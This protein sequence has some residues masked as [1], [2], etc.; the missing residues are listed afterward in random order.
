MSKKLFA[1]T[2]LIVFLLLFSM[3]GL[4]ANTTSVPIQLNNGQVS[5]LS[6]QINMFSKSHEL[7][8]NQYLASVNGT[9]SRVSVASDGTEGNSSSHGPSISTDGRFIAYKSHASNLVSGDTNGWGDIFMY[10]QQ[11]GETIRVSV[12]SDGTQANGNCINA[13]ISADGQHVAFD[14][15]AR[16]LVIGDNNGYQDIFV[17]D[18]VTGQT[19]LVSVGSNS[20]QTNQSSETPS[21]SADGSNVAFMSYATNISDPP[22]YWSQVFAHDRQTGLTER[23][24]VA[25]DGTV[26]NIYS[27]DPS[28]SAD[29]RYV[30][31]YSPGNNLVNGDTNGVGDVFLHDQQTGETIR[32]SVA[33]NGTQGNGSSGGG[34]ISSDG[35]YVAFQSSANNLVSED[36]NGRIDI[37]VHDLQTGLTERVSLASDG[38]EGN[39][40]SGAPSISGDGRYVTFVSYASN[41]VTGDTNGLIDVFVHDRQTGLT[42]RVSV[43]SDGTE[44]N[45][46][47]FT[48]SISGDGRYVTFSSLASNLVIGDNNGTYDIFV[49][50]RGWDTTTTITSDTPDPS[51]VG[52]PITVNFMVDGPPGTNMPTGSVTVTVEG[53]VEFCNANLV[54]GSGSCMITITNPGIYTLIATYGGDDNFNG[55]SDVEENT[56]LGVVAKDDS[57]SLVEGTILDQDAPGGVLSNDTGVGL[58]VDGYDGTS[59]FD[60][61]VT[62]NPDGSFVYTPAAGFAG[63]DTFSYTVV[64]GY[65]DFDTA[66]VE[67]I[68]N[69]KNQRSIEIESVEGTVIGQNLIGTVLISDQSENG[70]RDDLLVQIT[71]FETFVWWKKGKVWFRYS[72]ECAN[73]PFVFGDEIVVQ[74]ECELT[75][76]A[77]EGEVF[78]LDVMV[79]IFGREKGIYV[80]QFF[81]EKGGRK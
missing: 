75:Q 42:E 48:P 79:S 27:V 23:V 1:V 70:N 68:V 24:S 6:R 33:S 15:S 12:A 77:Q 32:V 14:S 39:S 34:R 74:Y 40:N 63:F 53:S 3:S 69:V 71:N 26:G 67:M 62:M 58:A 21:I 9:T 43:A 47:P 13:S 78:G 37:F 44:G 30:V 57:Y 28:I 50:D 36:N 35:R 66:T 38:T 18:L 54:S 52:D 20:T 41:I 11:T 5:R 73:P 19:E 8:V 31:F 22:H 46:N 51:R 25:S 59:Q 81:D 4:A 10:D 72:A 65:G 56:V 64:D 2:L 49:H 60:G 55:S 7:S 29:G 17:H 61:T 80:T 76:D 16:N 45:G